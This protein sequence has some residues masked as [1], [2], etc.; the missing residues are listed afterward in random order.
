LRKIKSFCQFGWLVGA[1]RKEE[2]VSNQSA[3]RAKLAPNTDPLDDIP[4]TQLVFGRHEAIFREGD[5]AQRFFEVKQGSVILYKLLLDG[6]RQVV[7][8]VR[9]GGICGFSLNGEYD[10]TCEALKGAILIAYEKADL[11]K[12]TPMQLRLCRLIESHVTGLHDHAVSL[13]RRTA[14]ERLGKFLMTLADSGG[15][16][17]DRY[18]NETVTI[19]IPMT[20]AEM[21]DYLGLSLETVCRTLTELDRR[22]IVKI[23]RSHG[24]LVI[25]AIC[26]LCRIVLGSCPNL[27]LAPSELV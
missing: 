13:G 3:N 14:T 12:S 27:R 16:A 22:G 19:N 8:F 2:A 6:R 20:R 15:P 17:C 24:D 26:D 23:G 10:A 5:P 18:S 11:P 9:P 4:S 7:D 21:A 25:P 1:V